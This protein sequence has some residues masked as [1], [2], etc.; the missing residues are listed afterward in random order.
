MTRG[1]IPL[2]DHER[3]RRNDSSRF[4]PLERGVKPPAARGY[5]HWPRAAREWW[6]AAKQSAVS[7]S[8]DATDWQMAL[9]VAQLIADAEV[10]RSQKDFTGA[11]TLLS[12]VRQTEDRLLLSVRSRRSA[13]ISEEGG[14]RSKKP[15]KGKAGGYRELV[16]G[17]S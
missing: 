5:N 16:Q 4:R 13:R 10:M 11:K 8:Y 3:Q 7:S 2:P 17:N 1:P 9:R 6:R 12:E 15:E 14:A